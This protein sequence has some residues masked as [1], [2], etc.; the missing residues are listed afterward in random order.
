MRNTTQI[1][2]LEGISTSAVNGPSESFTVSGE[3]PYND[4]L[5]VESAYIALSELKDTMLNMRL[6]MVVVVVEIRM[7]VPKDH[8]KLTVGIHTHLYP[9]K[10]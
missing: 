5:L 10:L 7:L 9:I 8:N 2:R 6:N 4:L 1:D 3:G